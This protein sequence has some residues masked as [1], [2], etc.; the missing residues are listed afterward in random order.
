MFRFNCY[1]ALAFWYGSKLV[2]RSEMNG[3]DVLVVFM[4]MLLGAAALIMIPQNAMAVAQVNYFT[5][6]RNKNLLSI[7][8]TS[9]AGRVFAVIDRVPEISSLSTSILPKYFCRR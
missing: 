2:V 7:K 4:A 1:I 9:A 5:Y 8:A 6:N 3:A